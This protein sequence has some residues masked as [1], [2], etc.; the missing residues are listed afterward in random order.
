VIAFDGLNGDD[1]VYTDILDMF[2]WDRA[3]REEKVL[4][5]EE[6]KIMYSTVKLNDGSISGADDD[7]VL[8][9][10]GC[11]EAEDVRSDAAFWNGMRAIAMDKEP[12]AVT[13]IE[14]ESLK[15]PDISKWEAFCGKYDHPDDAEL[16]IEEVFLKDGDLFA[17]GVDED[18]RDFMSK[19]YP[20][21]ENR[22]SMKRRWTHFI[23]G[24]NE[25]IYDE[26]K[27]RKQ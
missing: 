7:R 4:I 10:M 12:G 18:G 25:L 27:C 21:G 16:I 3:L 26:T 11:R 17:K 13:S 14:D 9:F 22:F 20:I 19:F 15:D 8:I 24:D 1:Y 23:F 5:L 2:I 6:Q